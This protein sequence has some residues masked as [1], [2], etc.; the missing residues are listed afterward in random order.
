MTGLQGLT[1]EYHSTEWVVRVTAPNVTADLVYEG[2]LA[3]PAPGAS[4]VP[5]SNG[6][7]SLLF[8]GNPV[9][10]YTNPELLRV[11]NA[12]LPGHMFSG[13]VHR[14][15]EVENGWFVIKTWGLGRAEDGLSKN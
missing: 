8:G 10:H 2:L 13:V 5:V 7:T 9:I 4:G 11:T 1:H 14:Q 6:A 3:Y 12:T 15:V